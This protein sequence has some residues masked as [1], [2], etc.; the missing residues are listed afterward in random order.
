MPP[1][2]DPDRE[3]INKWEMYK[4]LL[5]HSIKDLQI[6]ETKLLSSESLS[7]MLNEYPLLY[8]KSIASWGG[9]DIST[10][11]L[12]G[13]SYVWTVQ[14]KETVITHDFD[15]I[16]HQVSQFHQETRTIIQR[17]IPTV[18]YDHRPFDIRAH[19]YK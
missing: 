1:I 8:I 19:L 9:K 15:E 12:N 3:F 17:G 2:L 7:S 18:S 5:L 16:Y 14:G 13:T 4:L 6:P 10:I 11:Q